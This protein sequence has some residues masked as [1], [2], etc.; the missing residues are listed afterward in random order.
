VTDLQLSAL[1]ER[2][3]NAVEEMAYTLRYPPSP[4]RDASTRA[5]LREVKT[6]SQEIEA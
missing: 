2:L 1:M 5:L 3:Q 4:E 6:I